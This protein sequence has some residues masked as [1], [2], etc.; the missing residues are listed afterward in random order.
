MVARNKEPPR[1]RAE[2]GGLH[3]QAEGSAPREQEPGAGRGREGCMY[4][5][6]QLWPQ[7]QGV[8]YL[9]TRFRSRLAD[10]HRGDSGLVP[11]EGGSGKEGSPVRPAGLSVLKTLCW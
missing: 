7:L 9:C 3:A 1:A 8:P 10:L 2:V 11:K 5:G 6:P 4:K